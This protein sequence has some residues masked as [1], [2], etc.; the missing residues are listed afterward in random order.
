MDQVTTDQ[1]IELCEDFRH[2]Q[3][4]GAAHAIIER[5]IALA[6]SSVANLSIAITNHAV[7]QLADSD[8]HPSPGGA[9]E[10]LSQGDIK[11]SSTG[12]VIPLTRKNKFPHGAKALV[13]RIGKDWNQKADEFPP[14]A[15]RR[16]GQILEPID[17]FRGMFRM[18]RITDDRGRTQELKGSFPEAIRRVVAIEGRFGVMSA[19]IKL[20]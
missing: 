5:G 18:S 12:H 11:T 3:Q 9:I 15:K 17:E 7:K 6:R 10:G 2:A 1:C 8:C 4:H 16:P 19:S 13:A 20:C 14:M